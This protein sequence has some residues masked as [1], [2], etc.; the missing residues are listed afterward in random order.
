MAVPPQ[1][2]RPV[3][4]CIDDER[5][6]LNALTRLLRREPYELVTT[7]DPEAAL[8]RVRAGGVHLVVADYRMPGIS[9]T[10]LLQVVKASSPNTVRIMLTG[11]PKDG[12]IQAAEANGLM[13]VWAKPWDDEYIKRLIRAELDLPE[14]ESP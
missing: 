4:L 13:R 11:Y 6:V 10:S 5:P 3:V 7:D 12:W 9:G 8:D 2:R 1:A 14:T